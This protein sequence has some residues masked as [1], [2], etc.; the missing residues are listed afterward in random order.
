VWT[1]T[2]FFCTPASRLAKGALDAA[3]GHRLGRL[4]GIV[5][6]M[7]ASWENKPGMAMSEPVLAQQMECGLGQRNVAVL[8]ALAAVDMDHHA[9]AVD[10][11][12]FEMAR[13]VK[14]QA[15]GIHG[16][17]KEVVRE[18][19]DLGQKA[20]DLFD[21]QDGWQAVFVL[22]AQD[23]KNVPVARQHMDV[24]KTN[25]AVADAHRF[26][27]PAVDV[28]TMEEVLLELGFADQIGSLVIKLREHPHRAGIGFLSRF[29][30]PIELQGCNHALIPIVHK[31]SPSKNKIGDSYRRTMLVG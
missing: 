3:L 16:G 21:A 11:G 2:P 28:F 31:D 15:A 24:E 29:S 12:D 9:P 27:R 19:F 7:A 14:A 5:S 10:I 1:A 26:G 30:F 17:E 18:V 6:L 25:A 8:G 20:S 22:G 4:M 13:F 23:G